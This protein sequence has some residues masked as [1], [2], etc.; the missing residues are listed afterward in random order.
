MREQHHTLEL[1]GRKSDELDAQGID[2][3]F[4]ARQSEITSCANFV[5]LGRCLGDHGARGPAGLGTFVLG[6]TSDA[7]PASIGL[8]HEFHGGIDVGCGVM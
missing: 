2:F 6:L 7:I 8:E 3:A 4:A 1:I 5:E